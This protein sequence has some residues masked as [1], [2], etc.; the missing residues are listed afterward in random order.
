MN[1]KLALILVVSLY[2]SFITAS[3]K[4]NSIASQKN[5]HQALQTMLTAGFYKINSNLEKLTLSVDNHIDD[6][7]DRLNSL[8][9][10]ADTLQE[11][12]DE[13]DTRLK[14]VEVYAYEANP[15]VQ[16][17]IKSAKLDQFT[18]T[19]EEKRDRY[20]RGHRQL[21]EVVETHISDGSWFHGSSITVE[22]PKKI[23]RQK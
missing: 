9:K 3:A 14:F 10:K 16:G 18:T 11:K 20:K 17:L 5:S 2:S 7:H 4:K 1:K 21:K 23:A 6:I 22:D 19:P 13:I 8:E 15:K 12:F